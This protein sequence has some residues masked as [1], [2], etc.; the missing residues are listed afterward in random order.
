MAL[1]AETVCDVTTFLKYDSV[2]I[3]LYLYLN[4]CCL[5]LRRSFNIC[6][7]ILQ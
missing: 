5:S 7:E 1:V 3:V 2:V 4:M 6:T